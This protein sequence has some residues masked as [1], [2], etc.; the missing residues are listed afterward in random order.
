MIDNLQ[1]FAERKQIELTKTFGK[2]LRMKAN[3]NAVEIVLR[4]LINNA[5]KFS[6]EESKV[7]VHA[8]IFDDKIDICVQDFGI[9]ISN[10]N[11]GKLFE[12]TRPNNGT[13]HE[14]GLGI[15]LNLCKRIIHRI[16]GDIWAESYENKGSTFCISLPFEK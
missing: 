7:F 13:N 5:I 11:F 4:N 12:I 16:G 14:K 1:P 8:M 3:R 9:G 6:H 2:S 15:G 10:E